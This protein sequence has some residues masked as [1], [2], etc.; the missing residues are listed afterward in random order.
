MIQNIFPSDKKAFYKGLIPFS[1][2]NQFLNIL[3]IVA[4]FR[5]NFPCDLQ[6]NIITRFIVDQTQSPSMKV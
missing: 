1:V 2:M 5:E 3:T 4:G 6:F